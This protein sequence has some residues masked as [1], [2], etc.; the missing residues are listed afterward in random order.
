MSKLTNKLLTLLLV[1]FILPPHSALAAEPGLNLINNI[2]SKSYVPNASDINW[3]VY[4]PDSPDQLKNVSFDVDNI[5]LRLHSV[6]TDSGKLMLGIPGQQQQIANSWCQAVNSLT[7]TGKKIF[8]E[9]F[10]ELEHDYERLTPQ[11]GIGLN[12]AIL[13]ANNFI[14]YLRSCLASP[15]TVISPALDPQ[16]TDFATTSQAFSNF[17]IISCHPYRNDTIDRCTSGPLANKQYLFT[18]IGVDKGGAKYDNCLFINQFCQEN[19]IQKLNDTRGL[20]AYF[21]FTFAPGNFAGSWQLTSSQVVSALK[22][23]CSDDLVLNCEEGINENI[24]KIVQSIKNNPPPGKAPPLP[25]RGINA[26]PTYYSKRDQGFWANIKQ[27]ISGLLNSLLSIQGGR[28]YPF[29]YRTEQY[30]EDPFTQSGQMDKDMTKIIQ[31]TTEV[32][33]KLATITQGSTSQTFTINHAN[34]VETY[35]SAEYIQAISRFG[36]GFMFGTDSDHYDAFTDEGKQALQRDFADFQSGISPR[37]T[38]YNHI[39][40]EAVNKVLCQ[41]AASADP[42]NPYFQQDPT[43]RLF[44][45]V[46]GYLTPNKESS[47]VDLLPIGGGKTTI[48]LPDRTHTEFGDDPVPIKI[49]TIFCINSNLS[50]FLAKCSGMGFGSIS[51]SV[52]SS[53][54]DWLKQPALEGPIFRTFYPRLRYQSVILSKNASS[55]AFIERCQEQPMS[56]CSLSTNPDT[57]IVG[58]DFGS[59]SI[60]T[61]TEILD[62]DDGSFFKDK[63]GT[64]YACKV[65]IFFLTNLTKANQAASYVSQSTTPYKQDQSQDQ[66]PQTVSYSSQDI[67]QSA[68]YTPDTSTPLGID[69]KNQD[70]D[71]QSGGFF[72]GIRS[73]FTRIINYSACQVSYKTDKEGNYFPENACQAEKK[74][75]LETIVYVPSDAFNFVNSVDTYNNYMIPHDAQLKTT[76]SIRNATNNASDVFYTNYVIGYETGNQF[77]GL[78][79]AKQMYQNNHQTS[80]IESYDPKAEKVNITKNTLGESIITDLYFTPYNWQNASKTDTSQDYRPISDQALSAVFNPDVLNYCDTIR[81]SAQTHNLGPSLLAALISIESAGDPGAH[82]NCGAIGLMQVMPNDPQKYWSDPCKGKFDPSIFASRPSSSQ[83]ENPQYNIQYGTQL[84]SNMIKYWGTLEAGL[85]HYGPVGYEGYADLIFSVQSQNPT[86]C[87]P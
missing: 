1:I 14:G 43:K 79:S 12:A 42:A 27:I 64:C 18:E 65:D 26:G 70:Y 38:S 16:S 78:E 56:Q 76:Q 77:S 54:P 40:D 60:S 52:C 75:K 34:K 6:W 49:S 30:V 84:L 58:N 5:V 32:Y 81:Q 59:L 22:G 63:G 46:L 20:M 10:N 72:E 4:T 68:V 53:T 45:E 21:L 82:S 61:R 15:T 86:A 55:K 19:F 17:D 69:N 3:L 66:A 39:N 73:F 57:T 13:R 36:P 8:V 7:S 24:D 2:N 87:S 31:P 25:A 29:N 9:P 28:D 80:A 35:T 74:S 33:D 37:I 85:T 67:D 41:L 48:A 23:Q 11:G 51:S 47:Y 62:Q 71:Y 44:D 83:L 50:S